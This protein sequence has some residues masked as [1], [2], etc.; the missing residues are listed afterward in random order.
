MEL[1]KC[2]V[3]Q[4]GRLLK[5]QTKIEE[6]KKML[7]LHIENTD[8]KFSKQDLTISQIISVLNNLIEKPRDVKQIGF[9]TK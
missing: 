1:I 6:L 3:P 2:F 8:N 9:N 5:G 4:I 7:M